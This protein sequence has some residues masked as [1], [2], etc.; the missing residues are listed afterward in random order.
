MVRDSSWG[1]AYREWASRVLGEMIRVTKEGGLVCI[2]ISNHIRKF[3][4]QPVSES[5]HDQ[6]L[7]S[8]LVLEKAIP[9]KTSRNTFSAKTMPHPREKRMVIC[10]KETIK[11]GEGR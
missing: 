8:G 1:E 11:Q 3:V 4:E 7:V 6:M 9:I 10:H 5:W 2:N